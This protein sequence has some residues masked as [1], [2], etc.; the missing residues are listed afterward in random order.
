MSSPTL[1]GI[2]NNAA[3]KLGSGTIF[4]IVGTGWYTAEENNLLYSELVGVQT[5]KSNFYDVKTGTNGCSVTASWDYCTGVGT[6]R[7]LLGK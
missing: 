2:V 4:P 6:P 1:A 5:Y 7:G 3:N